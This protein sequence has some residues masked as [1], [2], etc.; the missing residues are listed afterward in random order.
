MADFNIGGAVLRVSKVAVACAIAAGSIGMAQASE[1]VYDTL[2]AVETDLMAGTGDFDLPL[3]TQAT[4]LSGAGRFPSGFDTYVLVDSADANFSVKL[5]FYNDLAKTSVIGSVLTAPIVVDLADLVGGGV[6]AQIVP[7][8]ASCNCSF[9]LPE[10][11]YY[12]LSFM[13]ATGA[14]AYAGPADLFFALSD[15]ATAGSFASPAGFSQVEA[16]RLNAVPEPGMLAMSL[17][18]L[19]LMAAFRRRA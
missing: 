7:I 19:G 16:L 5:S 13:D 4:S 17:A 11:F 14:T 9:R 3:I 10:T 15:T 6:T 18:A 8:F 12:E 1:I 2:T